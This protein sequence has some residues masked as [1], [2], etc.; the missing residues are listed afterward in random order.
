MSERTE[1]EKML[2][3]ELYLG[4]DA[5]LVAERQRARRLI[6]QFNGMLENDDR[7][8]ILQQLLGRAGKGLWIEPPFYVDYGS[9]IYMG[10]GVFLNVDCVLLDCNT[11]TIGNNVQI[12]PKVQLYTAT[13]PTNPVRRLAGEEYA[14]PIVIGDNV[15]LG[16]G[17]IIG[18]G[19]T[20]GENTTIGAGSVVMKDIPA[21]VVAVGNP[22]RIVKKII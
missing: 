1:R 12:A 22:C 20:I 17:V 19:V 13:H 9:N 14:L 11:I 8:Q 4:F 10:D 16:G 7:L 21:N 15:W 5:E 2:S 18:P 3:G 6:Q